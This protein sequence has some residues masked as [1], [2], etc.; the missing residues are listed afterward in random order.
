[1]T[2]GGIRTSFLVWCKPMQP[3]CAVM[4]D[5]TL[6]HLYMMDTGFARRQNMLHF[7]SLQIAAAV[8]GSQG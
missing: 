2:L 6:L 3:P 4:I 7:D 8:G 1:M 5:M